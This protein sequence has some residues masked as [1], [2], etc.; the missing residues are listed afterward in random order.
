MQ[1]KGYGETNVDHQLQ[2]QL[3]RDGGRSTGES[4]METTGLWL[5][6]MLHW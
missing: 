1:G 5:W 2:I 6:L 3:E 4:W